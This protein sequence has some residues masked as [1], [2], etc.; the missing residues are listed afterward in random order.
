[1]FLLLGVFLSVLATPGLAENQANTMT[2]DVFT[3]GYQFDEHQQLDLR[4]YYGLRAGYNFTKIV[5]LE[6]TAGYVPTET[7][8]QA[9]VDRDVK[10]QRYG[11]DALIHFNPDSRL[12]PFIAAGFAA[13]QT[14]N[15]SDGMPDHGHGMFDYGVGVK[16][17]LSD[18]VALRGDVRQM[19]FTEGGSS[20][21]NE[22]YTVGLSFLLGSQKKAVECPQV[23]DTAPPYVTLAIPYNGT[24]GVP[25][26]R[27]TRVAFSKEIDPATIN[28]KTVTL[29]QGKTPVPGTVLAPN[30]T[31]AS[32]T[33]ASNLTP[34]TVYTG[35]V[36]TGVKDRAGNAMASDY[37]WS[38]KTAPAADPSQI[39]VIDKLIM[40]EDTHFE[41]DKA[42]LTNEGKEL[43]KQNIQIMKDNPKL[44]VRIAGYTSASGTH[45]YNQSL[46]ERRA[47]TVMA[48]LI[49][50]GGIAPERLET[51]GYGETRPAVYESKP[52]DLESKAAKAN[53]R[54]LFEVIVK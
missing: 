6:A 26:F 17:F 18:T 11:L 37:L 10:V 2:L 39:I 12:V 5:G 42:T 9:F 7:Q 44:K 46:S 52:S 24:L 16:Y 48:Y 34:D 13:T 19:L 30:S 53:M 15:G 20:R 45:E 49:H 32:F 14:K 22:E 35:M 36:T 54:V 41:F 29:S 28:A 38:F 27:K 50:E 47:D 3:G 8:S 31:T 43:L 21:T 40:L 4:S 33:Q 25:V 23:K 1:M 51:I